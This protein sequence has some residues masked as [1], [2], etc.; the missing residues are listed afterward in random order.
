MRFKQRNDY[1]SRVNKNLKIR[2]VII[3]KNALGRIG[4][5]TC[6][7]CTFFEHLAKEGLP[8]Y[9]LTCLLP[10]VIRTRK[11]KIWDVNGGESYREDNFATMESLQLEAQECFRTWLSLFNTQVRN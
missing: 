5:V 7:E 10:G 3:G 11:G 9:V 8:P 4:L 6:F 1:K 2:W